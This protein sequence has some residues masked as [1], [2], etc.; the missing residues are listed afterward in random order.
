M[1]RASSGE[2]VS[3]M[4]ENLQRL[5]STLP[6]LVFDPQVDVPSQNIRYAKGYL[7][8]Y[9]LDGLKAPSGTAH[10]LGQLTVGGYRIASQYW[11]PPEPKATVFV[12]HGYFDH[13]ALYR[14]LFDFL[15]QQNYAVVAFDLPGHG[16]SDGERATIASFD[17]YADVFDGL[18]SVCADR[19]PQPWHAVG[20]STG[21]AILLKHLLQEAEGESLFEGLALLAPLLHTRNWALNRLTYLCVHR[22]ISRIGRDFKPNSADA[23]FQRFLKD[24]DPLQ[25]RHIPLE[26]VGSMKRWTE[27]FHDLPCSHNAITIIQG[28]QDLT[29]DWRYNLI[30][31]RQKLPNAKMVMIPDA[32]HH[33]VNESSALRMQVFNAMPF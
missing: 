29:L 11:L 9:Q 5:Q 18:L 20:Q 4:A 31:F 25:S 7:S 13:S 24:S 26:W 21:G 1:C 22:F 15:L 2:P 6:P 32:Q 30:R 14:Q 28:D 3:K 33:L 16:L 8:H 23:D 19:L 10:Y 17:H 27:E 12:V